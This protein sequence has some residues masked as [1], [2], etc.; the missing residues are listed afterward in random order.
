MR[1]R[2]TELKQKTWPWKNSWDE[3]I[4][5]QTS[6]KNRHPRNNIKE[7]S[8]GRPWVHGYDATIVG[9]WQ[10]LRHT[11]G[12]TEMPL[13]QKLVAVPEFLIDSVWL[14][15]DG[16]AGWPGCESMATPHKWRVISVWWTTIYLSIY[17]YIYTGTYIY[18]NHLSRFDGCWS[19]LSDFGISVV[20]FK[21]EQG[22]RWVLVL[23]IQFNAYVD[24]PF[25][26]M[27]SWWKGRV[28]FFQN[29]RI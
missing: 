21:D 14:G 1:N 17:K 22:S 19:C 3:H 4:P 20:D 5:S 7:Y 12:A 2:S 29:E 27:L 26:R 28:A 8:L 24:A 9:A 16:H 11:L 18:I 10:H 6:H 15:Y 23:I 25:C 13:I